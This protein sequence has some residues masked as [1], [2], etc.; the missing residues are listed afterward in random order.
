MTDN[1]DL[2][3]IDSVAFSL[4]TSL[5]PHFSPKILGYLF[6]NHSLTKALTPA[7]FPLTY[8]PGETPTLVK[9]N[10]GLLPGCVWAAVHHPTHPVLT[11]HLCR[12]YSSGEAEFV[13]FST[14]HHCHVSLSHRH[15]NC[16]SGRHLLASTLASCAIPWT[17]TGA[18]FKTIILITTSLC[19]EPSSIE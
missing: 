15:L 19:I 10:F 1:R 17:A 9:H 6:K 18:I 11:Y 4:S 8:S 16:C 14:L 7:S 3:S 5:Y 2:Q 12:S 13:P